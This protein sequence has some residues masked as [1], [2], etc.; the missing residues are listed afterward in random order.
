MRDRGDGNKKAAADAP[1]ARLEA[2][3]I[4]SAVER[5]M[6]LRD[7]VMFYLPVLLC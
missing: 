2:A 5:A 1:K 7:T 4:T 3:R 6:V